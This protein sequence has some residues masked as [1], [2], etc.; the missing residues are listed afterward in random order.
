V[1]IAFVVAVGVVST[2]RRREDSQVVRT[3]VRCGRCDDPIGAGEVYARVGDAALP[4]CLSCAWD[5]LGYCLLDPLPVS[6]TD[7]VPV[8]ASRAAVAVGVSV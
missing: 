4:R 5:L 6:Q 7:A 8:G 1:V 3:W 2:S